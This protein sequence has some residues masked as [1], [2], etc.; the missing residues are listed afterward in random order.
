MVKPLW[1][2]ERKKLYIYTQPYYLAIPHL[3]EI[4][5]MRPFFFLLFRAIP[6]AY[7]SSQAGVK[8]ELQLLAYTT[9]TAPPGLSHI[10]DLTPQVMAMSDP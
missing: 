4:K 7:R 3:A 2:S 5:A 1:K 9:P 10:G 6:A 8:S